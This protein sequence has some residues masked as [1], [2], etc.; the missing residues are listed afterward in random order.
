MNEI[1]NSKLNAQNLLLRPPIVVV[2]GHVDHG[3]TTL[4]DFIRKT[5]IVA[6][7]SGGI[8][9]AIGAYVITHNLKQMTFID[10]PGHEAFSKMRQRGTKIADLG[11][12]VVAADEGIK[13]QTKEAIEIL[14]QSQTPYVV[15]INKIDKPNAD[16]EK[17]KQELMQTE[18]F[19]EGL[20]GNISWQ[21]ISAK[22]GQG[23]N[24]LLDLIL[25]A[26]EFEELTYD[27]EAHGSGV[28]IE[29]K[30]DSNRGLT[31]AV[32]IKNGVL[33]I[34]DEITTLTTTG[35]IKIL[36]NFLGEKVDRL[37]PS[38]PALIL[39]FEILPQIGEEFHAGALSISEN[40]IAN[41]ANIRKINIPTTSEN[42]QVINIILKADVSGSLEALSGIIKT[43]SGIKIVNES[44][45]DISD[46]DV[47]LAQSAKSIII[48]FKTRVSKTAENLAKSQNVKIIISEIIYE[49][50]KHL[51]K[52]LK[53][54][55][56]P[57]INGKLEILA[58]FGK[59]DGRQI[60]GGKVLIGNFK[61]NLIVDIKKEE[62]IIG[63][64]KIINIQNNKKDINQINEGEECGMLLET[65]VAV[66]IGNQ[67]MY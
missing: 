40:T 37:E 49:L 17:I 58:V 55:E 29:S 38:N 44:I 48:G 43:F 25:L 61:N 16:I 39:G 57:I 2:M 53:I 33:K 26:A 65:K 34:N 51:E 13:P 11:I 4:L 15:A 9:Q 64:G 54:L 60:I 45:G 21:A 41:S 56:A 23:V 42:S 66:N 35:K 8:T 18:V 14:K 67:L 22:T 7:E 5:N 12:L 10:T 20:G 28:I 47:R 59:K 3:K 19:L 24:E 30:I 36:E 27:S 63:K 6:K 52:E 31:A 50:F 62:Q 1:Q 32:I 46:N